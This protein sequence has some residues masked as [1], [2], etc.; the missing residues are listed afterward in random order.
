[1]RTEV[2][3][4]VMDRVLMMNMGAI[5]FSFTDVEMVLRVIA[6]LASITYTLI[7]IKDRNKNN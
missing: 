6:L 2:K 5:A 3:T 7:K 4:F 1:V